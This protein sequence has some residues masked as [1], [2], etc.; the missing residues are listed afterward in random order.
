MQYPGPY[1]QQAAALVKSP[2]QEDPGSSSKSRSLERNAA[3]QNLVSAYAARINSLE[4]TRQMSL[5]YGAAKAMRSNSLTRQYSGGAADGYM[6]GSHGVRSASLE[7]GPSGY[8][9]RMGSLERNQGQAGQAMFMNSVKGGSL[10]RNQSAAIVSD[11]MSQKTRAGGS[12]ERNQ[13]IMMNAGAAGGSRSGSLERNMSY[14]SY[15][16]PVSAAPRDQEPFQEEIYDF[17]GVNVKSCA[18]IAL[19]KSVEKG[20]LPPSTLMSPAGSGPPP[21]ANFAL[22]PPYSSAQ[23]SKFSVQQQ[24]QQGTPQRSLWQQQ[25]QILQQQQQQ[26]AYGQQVPGMPMMSIVSSQQVQLP[27]QSGP[28][29]VALAQAIVP[30]QQIPPMMATAPLQPQPQQATA[31]ESGPQ[32]VGLAAQFSSFFVESTLFQ[33][34]VDF[35]F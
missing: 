21:A 34:C 12:L 10:E 11:M 35:L 29:K 20:M 23:S 4:R 7:R 9:N 5:E 3:G 2:Q 15:R 8:I 17:G 22:P 14:Q 1:I 6:V 13:H 16:S 33:L 24:Q 19:K 27:H 18:S 30:P 25:Q 28:L 31:V 32:Q 26:V